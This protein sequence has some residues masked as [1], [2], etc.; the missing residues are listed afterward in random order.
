MILNYKT[1]KTKS[2]QF[3]INYKFAKTTMKEKYNKDINY[4]KE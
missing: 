3:Y 2:M 4:N 1:I